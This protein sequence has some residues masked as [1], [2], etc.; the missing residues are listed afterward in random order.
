MRLRN[1]N[2]HTIENETK[3]RAQAKAALVWP[4]FASIMIPKKHAIV[5]AHSKSTATHKTHVDDGCDG[6]KFNDD[7]SG[8]LPHHVAQLTA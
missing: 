7:C 8:L 6:L 3:F 2:A 5:P 1:I 4:Q